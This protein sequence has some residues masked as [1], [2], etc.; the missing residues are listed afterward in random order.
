MRQA[1]Y[2]RLAGLNKASGMRSAAKAQLW[3]DTG[4]LLSSA[5]S[6]MTSAAGAA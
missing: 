3:S 2:E 6:M 5:G 1:D 4:S